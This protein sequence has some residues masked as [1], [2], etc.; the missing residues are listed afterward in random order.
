MI[1]TAMFFNIKRFVS[2]AAVGTA[3][4][5]CVGSI[6][7]SY[8]SAGGYIRFQ[9]EG[10]DLLATKAMS[11]RTS[12]T[13]FTCLA[14]K[15]DNSV[16]VNNVKT[17]KSSS[18]EILAGYYW[19]ASGTASFFGVLPNVNMTNS[20]G[21]VT[22]PV[23]TSSSKLTG[24]EDYVFASKRGS[25]NGQV[26]TMSFGHI[27]SN[28]AGFKVTAE[29]AGTQ[30]TVSSITLSHPKYGTYQCTAGGNSWINLGSNETTSLSKNFSSQSHAS[31][32]VIEG[33]EM[34]TSTDNLSLIP[35]TWT[36]RIQ[37]RVSA[38]ST[39]RT[40]DKSGSV[41]FVAGKKCTVSTTLTNDLNVLSLSVNVLDWDQGNSATAW[42]EDFFHVNEPSISIDLN[43]E[44]QEYS[45]TLKSYPEKYYGIYQA[46]PV[47]TS[48]S[49]STKVLRTMSIT[50]TGLETFRFFVCNPNTATSAYSP[51][52]IAVSKPNVDLRS[53]SGDMNVLRLDTDCHWTIQS[54]STSTSVTAID[55]DIMTTHRQVVVDG[56]DPAQTYT[57]QV[58]S[59]LSRTNTNANRCWIYI[60]KEEYQPYQ[61][62][63]LNYNPEHVGSLRK[64]VSNGT[65][66]E[67]L[68]DLGFVI[69]SSSVYE[70]EISSYET[71]T[72]F[73]ITGYSEFKVYL[74]A[75]RRITTARV[76]QARDFHTTSSGGYQTVG[77]LQA[78][79][80][81]VVEYVYTG[82]DP[83]KFYVVGLNTSYSSDHWNY[84]VVPDTG[85]VEFPANM[86][87]TSKTI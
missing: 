16:L 26:V 61:K 4:M 13:G 46:V 50:V 67:P 1:K 11:E 72:Q 36:V 85:D 65:R 66:P 76:A 49:T 30:T 2:L 23:G 25:A 75:D 56:L 73:V 10:E 5:S 15:A 83:S 8:P 35:G 6:E 48:V 77:V 40:Y 32:S 82:L 38:G 87:T 44:W 39:V 84:V 18:N 71:Y 31:G 19:P 43:D 69:G 74:S 29:S 53:K 51:Y 33:G 22:F 78:Y 80:P 86:T 57:I 14:L 55:N 34:G 37:Y 42:K 9:V 21:T 47:P 45:G 81:N 27:L 59:G 62:R 28:L 58:I 17:T 54:T 41:T 7:E 68:T 63:I 60:P 20:A 24:S 79:L 12:V 64:V 70:D 52:S 3:L